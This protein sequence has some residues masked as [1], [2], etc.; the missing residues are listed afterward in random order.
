MGDN[1]KILQQNYSSLVG[2]IS[3]LLETARKESARTVNALLTA[4]YWMVGFRIIEFEQQGSERALHGENTLKN[5]SIDL[6]QQFGKGF[7]VDNL[8]TMR[9][10][11]LTYDKISISETLSR[12]F[13]VEKSE[14]LSRKFS[15]ENLVKVF[16]LT[17]SHYVALTRRVKEIDAREF[18]E[19]EA[20]RNGWSVRQLERQISSQFYERTLLSKNKSKMLKQG[21]S[22]NPEDIVTAEE[23][24]K[25]PFI[26]EFLG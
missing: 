20:L 23:E 24:I 21:E 11:Y 7:S 2:D 26:L 22:K 25:D 1:K 17:W 3:K 15:L 10:F 5:L 12:K 19:R 13:G 8:E 18:Y 4:T 16:S 6:K 14:T 9:L